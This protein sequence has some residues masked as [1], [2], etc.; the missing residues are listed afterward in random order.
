[1]KTLWASCCSLGNSKLSLQ[2]DFSKEWSIF[3]SKSSQPTQRSLFCS[4]FISRLN[5]I[6]QSE[7]L[8]SSLGFQTSHLSWLLSGFNGYS[9][10][11]LNTLYIELYFHDAKHYH[12]AVHAQSLWLCLFVKVWT[13]ALQAPLSMGFSMLEYWS[14]LPCPP[15]GYLSYCVS[16]I[17]CVVGAFFTTEPLGKPQI[18]HIG[19]YKKEMQESWK[20]RNDHLENVSK[21]PLFKGKRTIF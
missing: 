8:H 5:S 15:P 6:W 7:P 2:Q 16:C 13:V 1:M 14:W 21:I 19:S 3:S 4:L 20:N 9:I 10:S 12:C 18:S 11:E 17:S